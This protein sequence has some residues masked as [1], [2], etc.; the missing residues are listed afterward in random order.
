[1]IYYH[2]YATKIVQNFHFYLSLY[3]T[4][5]HL[6]KDQFCHSLLRLCTAMYE[7]VEY[8]FEQ[9]IVSGFYGFFYSQN[10]NTFVNFFQVISMEPSV[11]SIFPKIEPGLVTTSINTS[12]TFSTSVSSP[13]LT[14]L[15]IK[16]DIYESTGVK[17]RKPCN[18]TK[19]QCLK[20]YCE[21]FANGEFCNNCNCNNCFN[22][23]D[24]EEAR[25]RS[26]K[27]CLERNPNAFRP[28]VSKI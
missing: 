14:P 16:P 25:Q 11:T 10:F 4:F 28:K 5:I 17:P 23:L 19:S 7:V 6:L 1:M 8:L 3:K 22:N 21:C 2:S 26:I 9:L 12:Q 18:C 27:Q 20:L 13:S 24:H 15:E